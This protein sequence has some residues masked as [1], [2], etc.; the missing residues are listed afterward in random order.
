[1]TK[2]ELG[3]LCYL[4]REIE[5]DKLRL[6][7]LESVAMGS[8]ARITGLPHSTDLADKTALAAEIA[9]LRNEIEAKIK[10]TIVQFNRLMRYISS[11][12]D[13]FMRQVLTFRHVNGFSWGQVAANVGGGNTELGIQRVYPDIKNDKNKKPWEKS[14]KGGKVRDDSVCAVIRKFFCHSLC[15]TFLARRPL[16]RP[17]F[18][19]PG[20]H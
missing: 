9:D 18:N 13:S 12:D 4:N 10:L 5:Q 2:K 8:V 19:A 1:M 20:F 6:I 16:A 3:Q 15:W 17:F 14:R 11:V 7:E